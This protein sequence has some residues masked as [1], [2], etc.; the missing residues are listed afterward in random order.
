[1]LRRPSSA[2][3]T[4]FG[5]HADGDG[6]IAAGADGYALTWMDARVGDWVVTPRRGKPVEVNALWYNAVR[7]AEDLAVLTRDEDERTRLNALAARIETSFSE[8]FWN[9]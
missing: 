1:M 8:A 5:I 2:S 6:L 7:F 4:H 9:E 3:G